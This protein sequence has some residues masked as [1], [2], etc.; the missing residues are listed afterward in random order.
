MELRPE[1]GV[2]RPVFNVLP[3][4]CNNL[5]VNVMFGS[6]KVYQANWKKYDNKVNKHVQYVYCSSVLYVLHVLYIVDKSKYHP[7]EEE[8]SM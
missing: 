8:C 5:R 4:S 7:S 3:F 1:E 2:A 6:M